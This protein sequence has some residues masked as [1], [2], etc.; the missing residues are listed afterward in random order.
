[1]ESHLI[2]AF[3]R[4]WNTAQDWTQPGIN[5][6]PTMSDQWFAWW[7]GYNDARTQTVH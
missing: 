5:P 2:T 4:G 7:D 3:Q 1:M 6:Y